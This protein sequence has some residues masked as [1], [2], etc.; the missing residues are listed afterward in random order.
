MMAPLRLIHRGCP[1]Q[2]SLTVTG[3][4]QM[5]GRQQLFAPEE[6]GWGTF[7]GCNGTN[8]VRVRGHICPSRSWG[9]PRVAAGAIV[10]LADLRCLSLTGV[11]FALAQDG[12]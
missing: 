10:A 6:T 4:V 8:A 12:T 1:R 3:P 11:S 2:V 5:L 7:D 9:V